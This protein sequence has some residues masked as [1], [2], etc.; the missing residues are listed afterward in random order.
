MVRKASGDQWMNGWSNSV[1]N[2]NIMTMPLDLHVSLALFQATLLPLPQG[3]GLALE[4]GY[5]L[6]VADN[7]RHS[8]PLS[9]SFWE[10]YSIASSIFSHKW[11]RIPKMGS[12]GISTISLRSTFLPLSEYCCV[13]PM[14]SVTPYMKSL[15]GCDADKTVVGGEEWPKQATYGSQAGH[16]KAR[17]K[18]S[19]IHFCR[20]LCG[21]W[22][23]NVYCWHVLAIALVLMSSSPHLCD[24]VMCV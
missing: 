16:L 15:A 10:A 3:S 12:G 24:D 6:P 14:Q 19:G 21:T 2:S 9:P 20:A 7:L 5:C 8:I 22:L 17:R 13:S 1:I 4:Q 23:L 11:S 18:T